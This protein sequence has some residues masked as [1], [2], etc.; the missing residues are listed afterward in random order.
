MLTPPSKYP[1]GYS[2]TVAD[3]EGEMVT[4]VGLTDLAQVLPD[5]ALLLEVHQ[6]AG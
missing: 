6:S 1:G 4:E 3:K 5:G 2:H